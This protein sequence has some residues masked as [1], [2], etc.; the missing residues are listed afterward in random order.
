M[1]ALAGTTPE[2]MRAAVAAAGAK[3][4]RAKQIL[5]WVYHRGAASLD[6]M[7]N[8]PKALRERLTGEWTARTTRVAH[9]AESHDGTVK[10]LI[11]CADGERVE[12]VLIPEGER[13][14]LCI[15]SQVGCAMACGFC[16][17]GTM[18]LRRNCTAAEIVEQV[19]WA[20]E[21][22][23][24]VNPTNVVF[25]GMGEPLANFD[26]VE[27]A[28]R[29]LNAPWGLELGARRITVSTVGLPDRIRDLAKLDLAVNLAV[30]LHAPTDAL[31]NT[32]VP[33]NAQ[34]GILAIM[35]AAD[36]YFRITGRRVTFEYV[37]LEGVNDAPAQAQELVE[38]L[39]GRGTLVNLLPMNPVPG[40]PYRYPDQERVQ[41]FTQVLEDAGVTFTLR[42]RRGDDI[43]AACGQLRLE[44][45]GEETA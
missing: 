18:G 30:S 31:R 39:D 17:T 44:A 12:A 23:E 9:R 42:R 19:L 11:E 15:S 40:L 4:F 24:G 37:L 13:R 38:L 33:P 5:E 34:I 28:I 2:E 22:L 10:F 16:A 3:P 32:L 27:R 43:A 36:D 29:I 8:L 20:R 6:A 14:T 25:M 21:E 1:L 26:A 7:D 45:A 35:D 41:A